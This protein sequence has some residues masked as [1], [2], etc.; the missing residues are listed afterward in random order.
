M[1]A[2]FGIFGGLYFWG[3]LITG[4]GYHEGRAM[5]HFWLLFIGVNMTF[6]PQHF[7]GLAGMPR[8]MFD[9]ADCFAGW[10]AVSS[11]GASISFISVLVLATTFQEAVRTTP[12]TA[13]TLEWLL[14]ATPANHVFSQVP[15]LRH[16]SVAL[17]TSPF[18]VSHHFNSF[19]HS[20]GSTHHFSSFSQKKKLL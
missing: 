3:N 8:R 12:R 15:V 18:V 9:Y 10:N 11:F 4:L 1:G 7:L 14:P 2:V 20:V 16:S 6:F 5:V 13:V 19:S 17:P